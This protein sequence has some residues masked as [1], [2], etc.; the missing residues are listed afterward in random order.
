MEFVMRVAPLIL[1]SLS[2]ALLLTSAHADGPCLGDPALNF[3]PTRADE[4]FDGYLIDGEGCLHDPQTTDVTELTPLVAESTRR[5]RQAQAVWFLNGGPMSVG[6]AFD[7]M[8]AVAADTGHPVLGIYNGLPERSSDP[9]ASGA[10]AVLAEQLRTGLGAETPMHLIGGS[11]GAE[12][13]ARGVA[14]AA[15]DLSDEQLDALLVES[16]GGAASSY[17]DGPR[18]THY[19]NVIDV[20]IRAEGLLRQDAVPGAGAFLVYL[21]ENEPKNL[22]SGGPL[23]PVHGWGVYGRWYVPVTQI[24]ACRAAGQRRLW[25]SRLDLVRLYL[26]REL[27]ACRVPAAS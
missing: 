8:Q 23:G 9:A 6:R 1:A 14:A 15:E 22:V 27:P 21:V 2:F 3:I 16:A 17:V 11:L 26:G 13:I 4:P 5:P 18:Y 24:E 20:A 7:T 19:L 25:L 10:V 12:L